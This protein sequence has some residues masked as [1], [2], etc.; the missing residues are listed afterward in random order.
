MCACRA[1]FARA[2]DFDFRPNRFC[3]C[4]IR[5]GVWTADAV[6]RRARDAT[7]CSESTPYM[8]ALLFHPCTSTLPSMS[9]L[10][11]SL[12]S[13]GPTAA[14]PPLRIM[15][16]GD[17]LTV[18][19]C[20]LNA[21]TSDADRPIFAPLNATPS[22][23]GYPVGSYWVVAPGGYR[24]YLAQMLR[25]DARAPPTAFVGSQFTCGAHEGYSGETIEWLAG[26]TPTSVARYRPDIILLMAGDMACPHHAG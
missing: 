18:F 1:V 11:A 10:P 15:P 9:S 19:D 24:G 21:F 12:P 5:D 16:M 4:D 25:D 8:L 22:I 2:R 20:R 23:L 13:T 3:D 26:V 7:P 6:E 17:S 14:A